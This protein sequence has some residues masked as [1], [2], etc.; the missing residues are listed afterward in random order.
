LPERHHRRNDY[1][2]ECVPATDGDPMA[3]MNATPLIDVMM[4][5][6][7]LFIGE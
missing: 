4:V 5:L 2:D 1:D 7:I 3:E 6:L